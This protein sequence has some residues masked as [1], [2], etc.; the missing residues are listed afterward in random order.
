MNCIILIFKNIDNVKKLCYSNG[1]NSYQN[2]FIARQKIDYQNMLWRTFKKNSLSNNFNS[3]HLQ[4]KFANKY[5][6]FEQ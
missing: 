6:W 5:L 3:D 2:I 1:V 4:R